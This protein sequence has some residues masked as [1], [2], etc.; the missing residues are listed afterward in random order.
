MTTEKLT[1]A[2]PE[3]GVI[4][5][6]GQ[7]QKRVVGG[8]EVET[9]GKDLSDR[10]RVTFYPGTEDITARF[11]GVYDTFTPHRIHAMVPFRSVWDAWSRANEAYNF[12]R[13]IA[14]A[15][16]D[17]FITLRDPLSGEYVIR[18]ENHTG[19]IGQAK[20]STMSARASNTG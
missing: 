5:K 11:F 3:V 20:A 7:K 9:V 19:H 13:L 14:K 6:G 16:D 18:N 4:R 15:N 12:G 8:W 17:C 1:I 10:F 2:F